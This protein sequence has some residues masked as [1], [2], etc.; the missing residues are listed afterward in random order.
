ML[1]AEWPASGFNPGALFAADPRPDFVPV[2]LA[3][4]AW[5]PELDAVD[6]VMVNLG[7]STRPPFAIPNCAWPEA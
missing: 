2:F 7:A 4:V 5:P 6:L 1:F 3:G